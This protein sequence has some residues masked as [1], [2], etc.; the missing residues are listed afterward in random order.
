LLHGTAPAKKPT[1]IVDLELILA[2][3]VSF[4][5]DPEEQS[6]QRQGYVD[7]FRSLEVTSAIRNGP[8]GRIAVT[9]VEWGGTPFQIVPWTLIDGPASAGAFAEELNSIPLRRISFTSITEALLFGARLFRA[10]EFTGLRRVIDVSGD[11]PN[12]SGAPVPLARNVLVAEGIVIDGLPI[13]LEEK[14]GA[15]PDLDAYYENCVIGGSGAFAIKVTSAADFAQAI[16]Q[17]LVLEITGDKLTGIEGEIVPVRAERYNC[18]IGE[19]LH[20]SGGG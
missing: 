14:A 7:A 13:M 3:D 15:F 16:R 11:G 5:M 17:K 20:E 1:I 12:N 9:Y 6:L 10:N 4:S 18:L 8:L 2:V 19:E